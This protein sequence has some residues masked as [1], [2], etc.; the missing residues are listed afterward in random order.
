MKRERERES[1]I[2]SPAENANGG[3]RVLSWGELS[4]LLYSAAGFRL[5]RIEIKNLEYKIKVM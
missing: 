3:L 5:S 1:I 2:T 4:H